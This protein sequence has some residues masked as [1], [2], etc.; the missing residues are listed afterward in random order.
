M[1]TSRRIIKDHHWVKMEPH[2]LGLKAHPGR[3]GSDPRLFLEA[4][5]WIVRTG[6]PWRDL[7]PEFGNWS[8][9]YR[10][11]PSPRSAGRPCSSSQTR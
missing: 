2:C 4:V 8:T 10:P 11:S 3:T 1:A 7:P 5:F 6:A 9:V